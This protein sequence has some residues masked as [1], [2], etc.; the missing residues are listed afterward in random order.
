MNDIN[1]DFGRRLFFVPSGTLYNLE[2]ASTPRS[3]SHFPQDPRTFPIFCIRASSR[4]FR[5]RWASQTTRSRS[6]ATNGSISRS[7]PRSRRLSPFVHLL[8]GRKLFQLDQS[9]RQTATGS[10][11]LRRCD[12]TFEFRWGRWGVSPACFV[13]GNSAKAYPKED[14]R[15]I[16]HVVCGYQA[17]YV[18]VRAA[19]RRRYGFKADCGVPRESMLMTELPHPRRRGP[20]NAQTCDAG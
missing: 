15:N 13:G 8:S 3:K 14:D 1:P 7:V 17:E 11:P 16:R 2:F 6:A 18:E 10:S 12:F 4:L 9:P 5:S 19:T 20:R